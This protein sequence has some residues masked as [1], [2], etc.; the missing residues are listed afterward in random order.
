MNTRWVLV[1]GYSVL[2]AW[3][4]FLTRKGRARTLAQRRDALV[5]LLQQYADQ[6][7]R[8]VTVVFDGTAAKHHPEPDDVGPGLQVVFSGKGQTADDVIE[9]LVAQAGQRARILVVSSDNMV[10]QTTESFG[11]Q[12]AS[13]ELFE[14]E[15]QAALRDLAMAVREHTKTR[16]RKP[17]Y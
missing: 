9:R 16:W 11:A 7:G 4:V 15:V 1:D 17:V 5:R 14:Q 3:A 13:S 2:H 8:L 10:R 6:T 12:S